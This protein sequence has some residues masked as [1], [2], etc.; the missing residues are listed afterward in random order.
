MCAHT[1]AVADERPGPSPAVGHGRPWCEQD[2]WMARTLA[3]L[4]EMNRTIA[5]AFDER[6]RRPWGVEA[7]VIELSKQVGDLARAVLTTEHYYLADRENDPRYG[8]GTGR[9]ANEL[10]DILY[11]V[12]RLADHYEVDLEDA[13][14]SARRA[15]W[16]YLNP[17]VTPP[18]TA[19]TVP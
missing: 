16:H 10:A 9:I 14:V 1:R 18:W 12:M 2:V 6:E 15:E 7:L 17:G 19:T 3:D 8:S 13:H 4:I 11:C 5:A